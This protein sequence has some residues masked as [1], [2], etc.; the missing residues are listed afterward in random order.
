MGCDRSVKFFQNALL[1]YWEKLLKIGPAYGYFPNAG[2]T[3]LLTKAEHL[4]R[5]EDLFGD[6]GMAITSKGSRYLGG[7]LGTPVSRARYT[8]GLVESWVTELRQLFAM[9]K[10]QSA[11]GRVHSI[12]PVR[13]RQMDVPP[14]LSGVRACMFAAN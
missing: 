10:T 13:D 4:Q 8:A 14:Q 7:H 1:L 3:I 9:A 5:A 2:K 6:P 11:P 12:L